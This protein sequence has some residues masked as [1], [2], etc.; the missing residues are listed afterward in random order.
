EKGHGRAK[1]WR[2][3]ARYTSWPT[4]SPDP[5]IAAAA[6]TLEFAIVDGYHQETRA[7]L[8]NRDQESAAWRRAGGASDHLLHLTAAQTRQLSERIEA[9]V[10]E[11]AVIGEDPAARPEDARPVRLIHLAFPANPSMVDDRTANAA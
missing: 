3:T 9:L 6:T 5:A 7:W 10:E 8:T 2:A 4:D 11:F 1:P